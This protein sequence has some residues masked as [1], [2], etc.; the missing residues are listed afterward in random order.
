M[1]SIKHLFSEGAEY[2]EEKILKTKTSNT[3]E[4]RA[5]GQLKKIFV[6]REWSF[7][8]YFKLE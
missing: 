4:V 8:I 7:P 2:M 3:I 1:L 5:F 6:A